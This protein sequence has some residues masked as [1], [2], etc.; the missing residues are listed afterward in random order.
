M[1]IKIVKYF[2]NI[3]LILTIALS[4]VSCDWLLEIFGEDVSSDMPEPTGIVGTYEGIIYLKNET[5]RPIAI[6]HNLD[7]SNAE[8]S[9]TVL[10]VGESIAIHQKQIEVE[11]FHNGPIEI[12]DEFCK[13]YLDG[14]GLH[15]YIKVWNINGT[16]LKEWLYN[17]Y[18][19]STKN[20]FDEWYYNLEKKG[21]NDY[22]LF[23]WTFSI[24]EWLFV[25][26]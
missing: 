9:T 5:E 11:E 22:I 1:Y 6:E 20:P 2:F 18:N 17:N 24:K 8:S 7:S 21:I 23:Q 14:L 19:P 26:D 12:D 15:S 4:A 13:N 25:E 10:E 16:L 3:L